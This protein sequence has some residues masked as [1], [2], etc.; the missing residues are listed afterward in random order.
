MIGHQEI[1][2][3]GDLEIHGPAIIACDFYVS[4]AENAQRVV[5]GYDFGRVLN[6]DHHAPGRRMARH[7]SSTN[8]ALKRL[9]RKG[10]PSKDSVVVISHTDCDSVL[11]SGIM[12]GHLDPDLAFGVAAIAADHTGEENE[13]ADLLQGI[14]DI[15]K[16]RKPRD[17]LYFIETVRQYL[18]EGATSLDS[19]AKEGLDRRQEMR[20][21][22]RNAVAN[23]DIE[24]NQG[25]A[26]GR[27]ASRVDGEL[28]S[29]LLPHA[30]A[31]LLVCPNRDD[32]CRWDAKLRLGP[33]AP[34]GSS[35]HQLGIREFDPN[36]GGRWN[37]GSNSRNGGTDIDPKTYASN[38]RQRLGHLGHLAGVSK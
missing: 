6:V 36:F 26:A 29:P 30:H 16:D 38:V 17:P 31:I 28:F 37:A 19:L 34:A 15:P 3:P 13:L 25:L 9:H 11:S 8:L 18:R 4:G 21:A 20:E 22:A 32:P 2:T 27:L 33:G 7:V 14:D 35:L 1:F 5:G 12:S 24:L 10:P 23:G